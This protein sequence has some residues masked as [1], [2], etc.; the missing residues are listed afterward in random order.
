[1]PGV[2][3]GRN[4]RVAW[5]FTNTGVDQQDYYLERVNPENPEEY[6]TPAGWAAF[7]RRTETI[8]VKG[9]SDVSLVVRE[10]RHGPVMS[11][12]AAVD[13]AFDRPQ[14]VLALRWSALEPDD[15]TFAAVRALNKARTAADAEAALGRFQL[16]TQSAV[17]AD[18]DG[19]IGMLVTG[20]IPVRG[21]DNDLNGIAPAPGWEARYDWRGYL[22]SDQAPR[23]RDPASGVLATANQKIVAPDYPHHLTYDWFLPYR[24][25][26]IE[27]LLDERARH[28]TK[29]FMAIQADIR[30]Q[31]AL[32]LIALLQTVQPLT[33]AG[34]DAMARLQRWDGRMDRRRPEP[35]VFHA[36]MRTLKRRLFEDDFGPLTGEF[37][38][39]TERTS[40]LLHVLSGRAKAR[41]WCDDRRT[42]HRVESCVSLAGEALDD[43]V[44]QLAAASGRDVA[45]LRW[46]EEHVAVG[47]H[48]PLSG[49]GWLARWVELKTPVPG[50]TYT[51]NV[52]ALSHR[53]EAP[54][55][56]R[57]APTL[58]AIYDLAGP[59]GNS[60]WIHSTGQAGSP[61]SDDYASMLPLW[62][63]GGYVPMRAAAGSNARVLEL[64]PR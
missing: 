62:R 21:P 43:A 44:G 6:A 46:G 12:L 29:T 8:R 50:D 13:K 11:G 19:R 17:Y 49:V 40:L 37:I 30:S 14:H 42:D 5:A 20:R 54:F 58:R 45:G 60:V 64:R 25:R 23:V 2:L 22:P 28:D 57:H 59:A 51:V 35:L 38:D 27:A 15:A 18:A 61:F 55:S 33:A 36:W 3:L 7:E 4:D 10:T 24:A 9:G 41:D 1:V 34:R 47:E 53:P 32:D 39:A 16:V 56:T 31:A 63:D 48:R 26:R 52:G